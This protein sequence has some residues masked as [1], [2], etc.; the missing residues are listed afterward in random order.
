M[1]WILL[2]ESIYVILLIIVCTRI[3]YDTSSG[4]KTLAY[5]LFAI[6]VPLIGILFYFFFGINYRKRLIYTKK[7]IKDIDL[8]LQIEEKVVILS[9]RNIKANLDEIENVKGLVKLLVND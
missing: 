9:K 7:L 4:P 1:N 8:Q 5:L 3:I 6:F 2:V